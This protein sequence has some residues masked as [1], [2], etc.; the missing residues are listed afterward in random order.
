[1]LILYLA[2]LLKVFISCRSFLVEFVWSFMYEVIS[3]YKDTS[4]SSFPIS[5][6]LISFSC[7]IALAKTESTILNRERVNTLSLF[8]M[9]VEMLSV[10]LSLGW[11]WLWS[12]RKCI[13]SVNVFHLFLISPGPLSWR[14]LGFT[15]FFFYELLKRKC[16]L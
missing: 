14:M 3:T 16:I 15:V 5:I 9:L 6:P 11:C 12:Y 4:T 13:C 10:S 8:L 2:T 1:M 7:L